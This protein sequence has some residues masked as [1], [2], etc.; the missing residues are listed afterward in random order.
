M[1][2]LLEFLANTVIGIIETTGYAGIAVLMALESANIP[3]P[4]E[5]I[6]PF[7]GYLVSKGEFGFWQVVFWGAFGNLLGSLVSYALGFYGGRAFLGRYG[8]WLFIT[9]HDIALA[10]RLFWRHG[11]IIAF[12][13][14]VLPVVRTFISFPAGIAR[15]NIWKFS[16]YTFAGSFLWSGLLAYIGVQL[17]ENWHSLEGYFRTFDWLIA[18]ILLILGVWWIIRQIKHL[19]TNSNP[20]TGGQISR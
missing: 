2:Y 15:M 5:I 7:A 8:K 10:D 3:I 1:E 17:G 19:K 11:A 18:G 13:S 14:R 6:M 4:S 9:P 20:P 16:L 12:A